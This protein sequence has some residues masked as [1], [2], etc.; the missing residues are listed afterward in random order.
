MALHFKLPHFESCSGT[1]IYAIPLVNMQGARLYSVHLRC[2]QVALLAELS[3][4]L[5]TSCI[6]LK[7]AI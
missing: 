2:M 3:W 6:N 7:C 4:Q 5:G 1:P